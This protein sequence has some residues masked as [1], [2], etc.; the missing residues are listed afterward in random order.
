MSG[1]ARDHGHT[2]TLVASKPIDLP[3]VLRAPSIRALQPPSLS[4]PGTLWLNTS[5]PHRLSQEPVDVFIAS[6]AVVPRRCPV[7][8]IAMVH[9]ITP[10]THPHRHTLANRFCFNAYLDESM[11]RADAIVVGSA[12]TE[13]EVLKYFGFVAPRLVRIGYG[14][15]EFFSPA[16]ESDDGKPTRTRHADGHRY[17]LH[18]GTIEPRKGVPDLVSAWEAIHGWVEDP[19]HL[20]IAGGEGWDTGPILD[21]ISDSPQR[22]RIH[23]PGYVHRDQAR[24]LLRHAEVFVLASE[25]EGFGLPLAEAI[26]CGVPCVASDIE[27]LREAGGD[28]AL[29]TPPRRP[30]ELSRA[31]T[32]ALDP[33]VADGLRS[34]AVVH[35]ESLRW[36]PV[37]EKWNDLVHAVIAASAL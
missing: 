36:G 27:S 3:D 22:D 11:E 6:L 12:A 35:A 17:I 5:L 23:L 19:P 33:P 1:L 15:D 25:V 24:Q 13:T 26:S 20:V 29:F 32:D 7:P 37:V 18:L 21:R 14:V 31:L 4:I 2:I 34:R 16:P 9:D 8:A 30:D 10:R 28:A